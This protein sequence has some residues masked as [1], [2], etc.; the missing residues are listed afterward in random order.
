MYPSLVS[1]SFWNFFVFVHARNQNLVAVLS[2]FL[3]LCDHFAKAVAGYTFFD[4]VCD[5][6]GC[7]GI[8]N[9]FS[10]ISRMMRS[11]PME[12]PH[13]GTSFPVNLPTILS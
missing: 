1:C 8:W 12:N 2:R 10:I 3:R 7:P 5:L 9:P 6:F 11:K 4:Q 13:A